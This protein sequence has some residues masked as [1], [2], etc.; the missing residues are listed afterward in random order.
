MLLV[1]WASCS[2]NKNLFTN[3]FRHS[4]FPQ[5]MSSV[6]ENTAGLLAAI[7]CNHIFNTAFSNI[8]RVFGGKFKFHNYLIHFHS[9]R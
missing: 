6:F 4:K 5:V 3:F 2:F 7:G 1:V 8:T 9:F